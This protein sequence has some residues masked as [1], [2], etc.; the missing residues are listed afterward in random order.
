MAGG[1]ERPRERKRERERERERE[2]AAE[3]LN[4]ETHKTDLLMKG[5][6]K[7]EDVRSYSGSTQVTR[8][9]NQVRRGER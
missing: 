3:T 7:E 2:A 4:L 1:R 8:V 9:Y 6:K 5:R